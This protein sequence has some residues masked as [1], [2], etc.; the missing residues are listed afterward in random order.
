[1]E[2]AQPL[3][4]RGDNVDSSVSL[5]ILNISWKVMRK[6]SSKEFA[7]GCG[8]AGLGGGDSGS[9]LPVVFS[10]LGDIPASW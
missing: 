2:E 6:R 10:T 9:Q 7:Q 5:E 1:M 4:P 3:Y 8:L